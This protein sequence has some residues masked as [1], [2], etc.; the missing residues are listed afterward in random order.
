MSKDFVKLRYDGPAL[1]NKSIDIADLAPSLMALDD[2]CKLANKKFNNDR[3]SV[4][5]MVNADLKQNCFE[6]NC[7]LLQTVYATTPNL[8]PELANTKELLKWLGIIGC[9]SVVGV[10]NEAS[11]SVLG[12]LAFLKRKGNRKIESQKSIQTHGQNIINVH[13]EGD[14]NPVNIYPETEALAQDPNAIKHTQKVVKPL[15]KK[16]LDLM[17]FEREDKRQTI[18]K[19]DAENILGIG[20]D[21]VLLEE[22]RLINNAHA[23]IKVYSPVYEENAK[24]WRFKYGDSKVKI[25][26]SETD[27]AQK[28]MARGA[29]LANDTYLVD[30]ETTQATTSGNVTYKI[31][32]VLE[33][34]P[35]KLTEQINMFK[36]SDASKT[37]K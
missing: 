11:L 31:K 36:K 5:V 2:L 16:G 20:T 35:A 8:F 18:S 34:K 12:L 29:A 23:L 10:V 24:K 6:L 9:N 13:I 26:I 1:S 25:D 22:N 19:Q 17:E 15:E 30:L 7:Q 4:K 3:A 37:E 27:I 28:A 14:N 33:F 32:E 21:V